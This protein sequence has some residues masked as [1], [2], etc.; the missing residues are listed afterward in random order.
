MWTESI[1]SQ[2]KRY[3]PTPRIL[4]WDM[5]RSNEIFARAS[6]FDYRRIRVGEPSGIKPPPAPPQQGKPSSP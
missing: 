6:G 1:A 3:D 2:P 5:D 4:L